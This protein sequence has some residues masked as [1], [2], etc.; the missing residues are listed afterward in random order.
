MSEKEKRGRGARALEWVFPVRQMRKASESVAEASSEVRGAFVSM[1]RRMPAHKPGDYPEGDIRNIADPRERFSAMYENGDW[2]PQEVETQLLTVRRTKVATLAV[3]VAA[4][5]AA[6]GVMLTAPMMFM[7][8]L[9]P[10]AGCV[11]ILGVAQSFKFAL[12]EAQLKER[13]LIDARTF[14]RM[15]D[16]WQRFL[17]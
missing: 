14:W 3:A 7:V 12:F 4:L 5:I 10:A 1:G 11:C 8:F 16:F 15:P 9:L 6:F 17:G 2:T 13:S